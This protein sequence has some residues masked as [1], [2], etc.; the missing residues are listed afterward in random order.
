ML[1]LE[2]VLLLVVGALWGLLDEEHGSHLGSAAA[3]VSSVEPHLFLAVRSQP[4]DLEQ[5]IV[6]CA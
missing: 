5:V 1:F 3:A 4:T 2:Q 6:M